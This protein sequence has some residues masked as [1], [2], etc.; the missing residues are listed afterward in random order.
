MMSGRTV[1]Y[2]YYQIRLLEERSEEEV[3]TL[4]YADGRGV[5]V[6]ELWIALLLKSDYRTIILS[7]ALPKL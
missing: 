3:Q 1:Q 6:C 2:I 5:W 4:T 7:A